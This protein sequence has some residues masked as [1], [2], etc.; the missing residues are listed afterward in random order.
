[1]KPMAEP[2]PVVT[3]LEQHGPST[4][5]ELAKAL[6]WKTES[7]SSQMTKLKHK[8][9][10]SV[11]DTRGTGRRIKNVW[12]LADLDE[13]YEPPRPD[14]QSIVDHAIANQPELAKVWA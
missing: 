3:H 11:V 1:M 10:V 12:G 13:D 7:M 9:L 2:H 14:P 6:G 4:V 5:S 8:G